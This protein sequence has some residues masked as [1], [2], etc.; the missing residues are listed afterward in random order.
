MHHAPNVLCNEDDEDDAE[1]EGI[2]AVILSAPA[3]PAGQAADLCT[4][5]FVQ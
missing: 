1:S 3:S 2:K 5:T 4:E